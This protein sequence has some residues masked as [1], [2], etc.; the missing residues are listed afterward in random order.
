MLIQ[1]TSIPEWH[2]LQTP[3]CLKTKHLGI[4]DLASGLQ[5]SD[6]PATNNHRLTPGTAR[7]EPST[8]VPRHSGCPAHAS[9][10]THQRM[11]FLITISLGDTPILQGPMARF[12]KHISATF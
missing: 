6:L 1:V 11:P 3:Q 8:L 2:T 7:L 4:A 5:S 9:T 12:P 10:C